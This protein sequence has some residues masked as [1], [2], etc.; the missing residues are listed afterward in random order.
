MIHNKNI[1]T[2]EKSP[3]SRDCMSREIKKKSGKYP[4]NQEKT[5]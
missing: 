1:K 5:Y 2:N 4:T 3:N